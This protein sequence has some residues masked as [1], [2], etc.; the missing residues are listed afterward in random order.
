VKDV[1]ATLRGI[2]ESHAGHLTVKADR[3]KEY[4]L[5][6]GYSDVWKKDVW[7]GGVRLGKSYVSYHLMAVYTCP[8]L[9]ARL[10]PAL[11]KRMQGKACFNFKTITPA[12]IEELSNLTR[13]CVGRFRTAG[14]FRW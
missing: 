6:A 11:R 13:E 3:P 1:F 7:F 9:L 14:G 2:L 12:Q 5:D 4:S 10:S 8:D